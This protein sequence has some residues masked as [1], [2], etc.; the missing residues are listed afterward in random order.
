VSQHPSECLKPKRVL[1]HMYTFSL[2]VHT[3]DKV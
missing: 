3:S 2:Y 1:N